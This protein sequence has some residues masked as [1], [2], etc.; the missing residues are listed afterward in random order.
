M[1]FEGAGGE[2]ESS[3]LYPTAPYLFPNPEGVQ[4][5]DS[6]DRSRHRPR[7]LVVYSVRCRIR[8]VSTSTRNNCVSLN[9]LVDSTFGFSGLGAS[10]ARDRYLMEGCYHFTRILGSSLFLLRRLV[11]PQR[12]WILDPNSIFFLV[13]KSELIFCELLCTAF[14][15][16]FI[17]DP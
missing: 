13:S 12:V 7:D 4:P 5:P 17:Y 10:C 9:P 8:S 1:E 2:A 14:I 16:S 15:H 6:T 3:Y 11:S